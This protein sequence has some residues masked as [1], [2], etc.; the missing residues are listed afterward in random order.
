MKNT[1][2]D[3]EMEIAGLEFLE[4]LQKVGY[5]WEVVDQPH[6]ILQYRRSMLISLFYYGAGSDQYKRYRQLYENAGGW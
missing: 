6:K 5:P 3:T 1:E 4:F 2:P